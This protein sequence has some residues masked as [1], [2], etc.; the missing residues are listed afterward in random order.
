MLKEVVE[1]SD[2]EQIIWYAER[3]K[4]ELEKKKEE[5]DK[6]RSKYKT[7]SP[8]ESI[9]EELSK[10]SIM[11]FTFLVVLLLCVVILKERV[12]VRTKNRNQSNMLWRKGKMARLMIQ[13]TKEEKQKLRDTA[14]R[15]GFTMTELI[16]KWIKYEGNL[17]LER[18]WR[19][20]F[21]TINIR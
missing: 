10:E 6:E 17:R 21:A 20:R 4:K 3:T 13:L 5:L 11:L 1:L 15:Y 8:Y 9:W 16:R 2:L 19:M 12:C 18:E 14:Y 7:G